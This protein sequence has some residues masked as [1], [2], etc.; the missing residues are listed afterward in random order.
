MRA[1]DGLHDLDWSHV[2]SLYERVAPFLRDLARP[3]R[4]GPLLDATKANPELLARCE[5][6]NL[7]EKVVLYHSDRLR[8]RLHLFG[9]ERVE[10]VHNHRAPFVAHVLHGR[11]RHLLYGDV[12]SVRRRENAPYYEP[13]LAQDQVP[14]STYAIGCKMLHSTFAEPGT[15][16]IILQGPAQLESFDIID[17]KNGQTRT[18]Y[19]AARASG[20]QEAGE[21]PMTVGRVAEV[22]ALARQRGLA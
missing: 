12:R 16:S 11:Y 8:L 9:D 3:K 6:F 19:G 7:F 18:R 5:R 15:M 20:V 10:E 21:R 4:L 2:D 1:L 17:L 13:L 14:G 22:I